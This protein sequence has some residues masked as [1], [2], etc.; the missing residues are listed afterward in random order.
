MRQFLFFL[1]F[2]NCIYSQDTYKA[3]IITNYT[4]VLT[5]KNENA[6]YSLNANEL[7]SLITLS[8]KKYH[9]IYSYATWCKSCNIFFP[10]ILNLVKNSKNIQL[11]VI[12]IERNNS[13][14]LKWTKEAFKNKFNYLNNTFMVSDTYGKRRYKK[15]ERFIQNIAPDHKNYGLSLIVL[16]DN[17]KNLLYASTYFEED[18]AEIKKINMLT[19]NNP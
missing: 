7:D 14:Y 2:V 5:N 13:R 12:N 4:F 9:L 16:F 6:I 15:Y 18:D 11:Y 17:N 19:K 3:K 1:L 8:P 10:K